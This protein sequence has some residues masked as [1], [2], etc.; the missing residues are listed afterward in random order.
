MG[1]FDDWH[2]ATLTYR[3]TELSTAQLSTLVSA[4]RAE[5]IPITLDGDILTVPAAEFEATETLITQVTA[6]ETPVEPEPEPLPPGVAEIDGDLKE[7][8]SARRRGAAFVVEGLVVA[9]VVAALTLGTDVSVAG[10][11][12]LAVC[13]VPV[14]TD[15][16]RQGLQDR[17]ANTLVLR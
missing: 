5:G 16:L 8:A 1:T 10:P 14:L 3:V 2:D 7:L 12:S 9:A 6:G 4:L 17:W 11:S 13:V 15:P